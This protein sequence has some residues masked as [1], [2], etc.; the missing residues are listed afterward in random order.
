MNT[1]QHIGYI[2]YDTQTLIPKIN[3]ILKLI[4]TLRREK[5]KQHIKEQTEKQLNQSQN[6]L[7]KLLKTKPITKK[8]AIINAIHHYYNN[9][10]KENYYQT[11]SNTI[12]NT[13][14]IQ[15]TTLTETLKAIKTSK[16]PTITIAIEMA[17]YYE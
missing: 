12:Q 8:Q 16:S 9:R 11:P 15:E 2:Q 5:K 10:T 17:K 1:E 14:K 13:Y 7:Q 3:K 4:K 6:W